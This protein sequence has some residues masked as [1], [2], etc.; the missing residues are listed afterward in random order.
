[1]EQCSPCENSVVNP[2][3]IGKKKKGHNTSEQFQ[4][5]GDSC[6][7]HDDVSVNNGPHRPVR[8]RCAVGCAI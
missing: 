2:Q 6:G 4:F 1:M 3:N 5:W 7:P 8:P